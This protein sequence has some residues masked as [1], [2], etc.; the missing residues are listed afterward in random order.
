MKDK[1]KIERHRQRKLAE[2]RL[3][4]ERIR[5]EQE[6]RAAARDYRQYKKDHPG[7]VVRELTG[8]VFGNLTVIKKAAPYIS[9]DGKKLSRYLCRCSCGD[10][11]EVYGFELTGGRAK[12][13]GCKEFAVDFDACIEKIRRQAVPE[14][15][16]PLDELKKQLGIFEP[17]SLT[18]EKAGSEESQDLLDQS[19][20]R[21]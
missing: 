15:Y 12:S 13:C 20:R 3:K 5:R 19:I 7:A 9:P 21:K 4:E 10:A 16:E 1:W 11:I 14:M 2:A 6:E 8:F 18:P 17:E